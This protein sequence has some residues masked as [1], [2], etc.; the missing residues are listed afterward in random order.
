MRARFLGTTVGVAALLGA[1]S[2]PTAAEA[3]GVVVTN[4]TV[5]LGVN[6]HAQL[7]VP[8]TVPSAGELTTTVGLRYVPTNADGI[9]PGCL[10]EGWG[11]SYGGS[12]AGSANEY[13]G[14][15]GMSLL[16]FT[17]TPATALS[18]VQVGA[19]RVTHDY[20]PSPVPNLYEVTVT[21]RN[22]SSAPVSA[23][24]YRRVVDW[25]VEPTAFSEY[26]TLASRDPRLVTLLFSSD[27]GFAHP[28]PLAGPT[29]FACYGPPYADVA[30]CG[31]FDHGAL[32]DL[33]L[34]VIPS[35]GSKSIHL[36]YGATGSEAQAIVALTAVGA[37]FYSLGQSSLPGGPESGTPT[38]FVLGI[39][40]GPLVIES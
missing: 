9:A 14:I 28:S 37:Q 11:V 15:A 16:A 23:A 31:P 26:V 24:R 10:C 25:D 29:A 7:N 36:Y 35:G 39:K 6:P 2:P 17:S 30:D 27:D 22:T 1:T 32:A 33:S 12:V 8:G 3:G 38:T 20:H 21:V 5:Q 13:W 4:G 18:V 19:L 40:D 34:G